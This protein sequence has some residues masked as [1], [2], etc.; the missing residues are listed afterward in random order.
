[1]QVSIRFLLR[2]CC[3]YRNDRVDK[4]VI[5]ES[6]IRK[7]FISGGTSTCRVH[8]RQHYQIYSERCKAKGIAENH[9]ALLREDFNRMQREKNGLKTKNQLT[10]DGMVEK[11]QGTREFT[12]EGALHAITQFVACDDQVSAKKRERHGAEFVARR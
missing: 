7:A 8:I 10:L 1:M 4:K 3:T 6:G 5:E 2:Q 9:H 11:V 12:R